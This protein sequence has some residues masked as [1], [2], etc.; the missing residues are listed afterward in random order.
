[1]LITEIKIGDSMKIP[2]DA[3]LHREH[4]HSGKVLWKSEDGKTV[5]IQCDSRHNN[6]KAVFRVKIDSKK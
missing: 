4:G 6:K 1:M 3:K 2:A 5:A